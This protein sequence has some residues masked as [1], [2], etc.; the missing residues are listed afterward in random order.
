MLTYRQHKRRV[1]PDNACAKTSR[2]ESQESQQ[3]IGQ[4]TYN[5][6]NTFFQA[7]FPLTGIPRERTKLAQ[8]IHNYSIHTFNESEKRKAELQALYSKVISLFSETLK[9]KCH[10]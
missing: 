9:L 10:Y 3:G 6:I 5:N 4:V 8:N 1:Y 2:T 7:L